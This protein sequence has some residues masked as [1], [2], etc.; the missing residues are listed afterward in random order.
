MTKIFVQ[1]WALIHWDNV[2]IYILCDGIVW[3][4]F[5]WQSLPLS[6]SSRCLAFTKTTSLSTEC[7]TACKVISRGRSKTT[8][9]PGIMLLVMIFLREDAPFTWSG[10]NSNWIFD[11]LAL[12][13]DSLMAAKIA[14][15][16]RS[17][18]IRVYPV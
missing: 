5:D 11:A 2:S 7:L 15:L 10:T 14:R 3:N 9:S 18:F 8:K 16:G 13:L 12:A 4:R 17:L 1:L 6:S